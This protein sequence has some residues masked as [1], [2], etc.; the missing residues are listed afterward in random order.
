MQRDLDK[1]LALALEVLRQHRP[2]LQSLARD[3]EIRGF[4][5]EAD[6]AL[7]L[8]P[9]VGTDADRHLPPEHAGGAER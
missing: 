5:L 8:A 6:L 1:A 3:L 7:A 9:V 2:L 4:L